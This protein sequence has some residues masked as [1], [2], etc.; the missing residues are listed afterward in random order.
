MNGPSYRPNKKP[1]PSGATVPM[2]DSTDTEHSRW[3]IN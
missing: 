3:N 2:Y 1:K